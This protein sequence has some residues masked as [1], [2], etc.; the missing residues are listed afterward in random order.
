LGEH[1]RDN[2]G[3][4]QEADAPGLVGGDEAAQERTTAVAIAAAAPTSA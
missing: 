3:L 1:D 4:E 2:H